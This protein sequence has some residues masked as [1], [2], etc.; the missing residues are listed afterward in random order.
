M[1]C[2]VVDENDNIAGFGISLPSLSKALKK[3]QGK[4]FPFGWFHLLQA[5]NNYEKIDLMLTGVTPEWQNKGVHSIYH[6]VLNSNY[7]KLG[8]KIAITNPQLENNDAHRIWLKYDS[9]ILIRRR[10]YKKDIRVYI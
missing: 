9:K 6:A 10:I 4:L 2:F 3:C 8:V 5:L 7:H 1:L